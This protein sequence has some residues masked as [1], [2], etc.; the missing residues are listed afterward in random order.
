MVCCSLCIIIIMIIVYKWYQIF[1]CLLFNK[2][3]I[4]AVKFCLRKCQIKEFL[5]FFNIILFLFK[6]YECVY[7]FC[8]FNVYLFDYICALLWMWGYVLMDR[9]PGIK[10]IF[11]ITKNMD[12]ESGVK[13]KKNLTFTNKC[14]HFKYSNV[15]ANRLWI[16]FLLDSFTSPVSIRK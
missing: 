7:L 12:E 5:Y 10:R 1:I 13:V 16:E 14:E 2:N 15:Y 4:Y 9:W 11:T 6:F 8:Y 3:Q